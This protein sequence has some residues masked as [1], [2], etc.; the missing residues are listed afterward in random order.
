MREKPYFKPN[1]IRIIFNDRCYLLSSRDGLPLENLTPILN[2]SHRDLTSYYAFLLPHEQVK[3]SCYDRLL[4][5]LKT[6]FIFQTKLSNLED[7]HCCSKLKIVE[8]L[9]FILVLKW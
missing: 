2:I 1:S 4:I 5:C 3:F 6:Q 9:A 7:S 8:I